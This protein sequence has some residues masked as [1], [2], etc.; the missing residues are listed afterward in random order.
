MS[1]GIRTFPEAERFARRRYPHGSRGALTVFATLRK[2]S[3][4]PVCAP[5]PILR[6]V[7]DGA[8]LLTAD[9]PPGA[10]ARAMRPGVG[11]DPVF[12][13]CEQVAFTIVFG[14]QRPDVPAFAFDVQGGAGA[15]TP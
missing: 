1:S 12:S 9:Q 13:P 4:E 3:A 14:L 6:K 8:L 11:A 10:W 5:F 2:A 7:R 15:T